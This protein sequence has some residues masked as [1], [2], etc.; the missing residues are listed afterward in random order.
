MFSDGSKLVPPTV[1]FLSLP[2]SLSALFRTEF[3]L[4]M[5]WHFLSEVRSVTK[6]T[7]LPSFA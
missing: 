1:L 5:H 3:P 2:Y 7:D 6:L 4:H